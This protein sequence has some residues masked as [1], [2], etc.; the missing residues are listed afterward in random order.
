MNY[1]DLKKGY[2]INIVTDINDKCRTYLIGNNW[3]DSEEMV[4]H[5]LAKM[6]FNHYVEILY[7]NSTDEEIEEI[8]EL[9]RE[10]II[11]GLRGFKNQDPTANQIYRYVEA[12]Y[13]LGEKPRRIMRNSEIWQETGKLEA[14][15][16]HKERVENGQLQIEIDE[17]QYGR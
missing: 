17:V 7:D 15:I 11:A 1:N 4:E 9:L 10:K 2:K 5:I 16:E 6:T 14:L 13:K 8:K 12:C 3:D